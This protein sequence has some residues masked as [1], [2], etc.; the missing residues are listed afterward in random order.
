[1]K[2]FKAF[3][4]G[5]LFAATLGTT[6]FL[7]PASAK[8]VARSVPVVRVSEPGKAPIKIIEPQ[9]NRDTTIV[10]VNNTTE[11]V[12]VIRRVTDIDNV[13][14]PINVFDPLGNF[15][16]VYYPVPA[17]QL[18]I[19]IQTTPVVWQ[20]RQVIYSNPGWTQLTLPVQQSGNKLVLHVQGEPQLNV[21][22]VHFGDGQVEQINLQNQTFNTGVYPVLN[23]GKTRY[24]ESV[25]LTAR[26]LVP[27]TD[28]IVSLQA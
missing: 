3:A 6:T 12:R 17:V 28:L 18:N 7:K 19:P 2:L 24:V 10:R 16:P 21:A 26:S 1:M 15:A 9:V 11:P 23:F 27:R 8:V 5:T 13:I 22:E 20:S 14:E 4:I 25:N